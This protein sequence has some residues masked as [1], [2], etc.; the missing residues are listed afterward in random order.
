MKISVMGAGGVGGYFGARL[1]AA[2]NDVAFVAR[3]A[4][5]AAIREHGLRV[6]S[7]L[8]DVHVAP[9]VASDEP[10]SIGAVDVVLFATKLYDTEEAAERSRALIGPH[11]VVISLQNGVDGIETLCRVLGERHVAG[12][13]AR[14]SASIAEPGVIGH[15]SGFAGISFGELDARRS[16][17]LQAFHACAVAAGIDARLADD[18][19]VEMWE[20]FI[21]LSALSAITSLTRLP[22]GPILDEPRSRTLLEQA[23]R[24][25]T[26]VARARGIG[27]R[28]DAAES[29]LGFME[30][31]P[32]SMK[33][34]MLMDLERGNRLELEWLS[35]AV[36]RH[37]E[38]LGVPTPV[39]RTALA[40]LA[41]YVHGAPSIPQP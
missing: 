28:A 27:V 25:V 10:Q 40:A 13:V 29:A 32:R 26:A 30:R 38:E 41:P 8:G 34:S 17:R 18:I 36:C 7:P 3:G 2:G 37:G 15:Y 19:K 22:V 33:A 23:V 16:E 39:H 24:E 21:L 12:G 4:H 35:G 1:A 6:R 31:M 11:T 20:K 14:I 5:L 9:V